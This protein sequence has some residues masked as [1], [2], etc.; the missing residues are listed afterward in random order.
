M[1]HTANQLCSLRLPKTMPVMVLDD[2]YL[3]P[4][5]FL[6]LFIFEERY[7]QMLATAL[8]TDRMFCIGC[9]QPEGA[10]ND[11]TPVSTAALV[12]ACRKQTD[13]TS[14]VMLYGISRIRF[15]GW[16]QKRPFRIAAI[17]PLPTCCSGAP[18]DLAR[19]KFEA[20]AMLPKPAPQCSEAM[21]VLRTTLEGM[22]CPEM[23]CDI[24]AYHFVKKPAA[25]RALLMEPVLE[26][27]YQRLVEELE[28]LPPVE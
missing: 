10:E 19:L 17:E 21:Q 13:G 8:N 20:L 1:D 22:P 2:C 11:L 15:T 9:R 23:V 26:K 12:R 28:L 18:E 5:C 3:F 4:G 7:R 24:L 25:Q 14:H 6:P 27:R 16:L